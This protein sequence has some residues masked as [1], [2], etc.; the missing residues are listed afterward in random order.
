MNKSEFAQRR[1]QLMRMIG[2]DGIAILPSATVKMRSR[3]AE[4]RYRQDS[5]FYYLTGFAEPDSV[6]VL[7]PGRDNGEFVLFCRDRDREKELWNGSRE[8]PEGAISNYG[9][10]DAFPVDDLDDILPG[11]LETRSRVYYAMGANPEFDRRISEWVK[12]LQGREQ[13]GVQ[14]P[15]EFVAL[16]HVLHDMRLYKSRAELAAMRRSA[17]IAVAAHTRAL[18]AI[19]PGAYEYEVEAEFLHEFRRHDATISYSP[20]VGGGANTCTLHYVDNNAQLKDG[21]LLLIDA[22]CEWDYYASDITRTLPVNGRYSPEQ[23]AI[24]E[25]VLEAQLAA[26]ERTCKGN[27]WNDPH[28]AA[29]RVITRGLKKLGLLQGTVP[30]LMRDGAYREFFMHRT[31]HWLGMDVHDVGDYRVDEEW[32][33]LEPGMVTTV[34][35]GIYISAK[36]NV[37]ARW[38][39]IGIRIEDDVAVTADDPDVLSRGLPKDPDEIEKLMAA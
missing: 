18:A 26:I 17:K 33:L 38:R 4:Y 31:G 22:G 32:R 37:P 27:H 8:G 25:I 14:S 10:D 3:D 21:D 11:I 36:S 30:K 19:R 24:Y 7:A 28:D 1:K 35:P 13:A 20:I 39:N 34:E 6:C 15:Q 16:D 29:V 23:R 9:A 2:H 12:S 5:D